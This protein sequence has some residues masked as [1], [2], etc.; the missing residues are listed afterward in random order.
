MFAQ[1]SLLAVP[2]GRYIITLLFV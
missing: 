2:H 1:C